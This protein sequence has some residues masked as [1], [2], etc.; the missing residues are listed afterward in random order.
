[1]P[2]LIISWSIKHK[3]FKLTSENYLLTK[4]FIMPTQLHSPFL[5]TDTLDFYKKKDQNEYNNNNNNNIINNSMTLVL[6]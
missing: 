6:D 3:H 1:M 5:S 4:I 2:C